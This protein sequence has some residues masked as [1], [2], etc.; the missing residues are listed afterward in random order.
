MGVQEIDVRRT[1]T[2]SPTAVWCLLADGAS[3]PAWSA[4]DGY[5]VLE[6]GPDGGR[7]GSTHELAKGR[8]QR[9]VET[10]VELVP[11]R[12]FSY[13]LVSGLPLDDYRA[14]VDLT[15]TGDGGTEI[16]WHSTFRAQRPGTGWIFR[17]VLRR[18]I[19]TTTE[20][21]AA[22]AEAAERPAPSADRR[23]P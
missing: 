6:P 14:D 18:F 17:L 2:A 11:E 15:P 16:R 21:L 3:W 5:R 20:Q 12:R 23:T 13:V 1:I 4:F 7:L 8:K 10:V 9:T 19:T 22:A